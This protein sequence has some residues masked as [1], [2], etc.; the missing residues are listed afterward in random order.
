MPR[1]L[2]GAALLLA[3]VPAIISTSR[4]AAAP[5]AVPV[6]YAE[7]TLHGFVE[8]RNTA[9]SLLARGDLLQVPRDTAIES[10]LVFQFA[11]SSTFEEK[12]VFTQHQVFTLLSYRL[13]QRGRAFAQD[14]DVELSRDGAY[15]VK[16]KS[17]K[18]GKEDRMTGKLDLP[19]DV[20][21]GM[22]IT[23][24]KN[25]AREARTVH[26]VAFT[27]KPL[28][29]PLAMRPNGSD[30]LSIGG[31]RETAVRFTL[32]P[33]LNVI[34]KIGAKLKGQAPPDSHLWIVTEDV[35]AFVRFEG[36]LYSGPVWRINL[37]SPRWTK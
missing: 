17:H 31:R 18:D 7:G 32:E 2:L 33:R 28:V 25:L 3:L 27:P 15:V 24:A 19:A 29:L 9:D 13:V 11:D 34:Q 21:N 30:P 5:A 4:D 16:T 10:R 37:T 8:L 6:R 20:Y 36:P 26:I 12:V 35:P 22:I 23:V 14:L 1:R